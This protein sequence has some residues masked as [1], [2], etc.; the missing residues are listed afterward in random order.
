M[1]RRPGAAF[2]P[3]FRAT[4]ARSRTQAAAAAALATGVR[5][6]HGRG[7]GRPSRPADPTRIPV[8]VLAAG[9]GSRLSRVS[10]GRWQSQPRPPRALPPGRATARAG[11]HRRR[12]LPWLRQRAAVTFT[13]TVTVT[14]TGR[15][16]APGCLNRRR[17][18]LPVACR[19]QSRPPAAG[20]HG[21]RLH[22]VDKVPC[23]GRV[24]AL[25][26]LEGRHSDR[27]EAWK[28]RSRW[29]YYK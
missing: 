18:R 25:T 17:A 10:L 29:I 27:S 4:A 11:P 2:R 13:V 3:T 16:R 14:I 24:T 28:T 19:R 7:R 20:S 6:W 1:P 21:H 26:P 5:A 22:L 8:R 9:P 23:P 12:R 15:R